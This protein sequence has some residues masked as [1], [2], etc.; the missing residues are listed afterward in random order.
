L[1]LSLGIAH[2]DPEA[3]CTVTELI[4]QADGRMYQQKQ[5]RKA[6]TLP[7]KKRREK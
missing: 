3:S 7:L 6:I 4:A 5:A 1:T 2:Y